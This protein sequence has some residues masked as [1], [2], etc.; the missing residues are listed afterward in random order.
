MSEG[1]KGTALAAQT[2]NWGGHDFEGFGDDPALTIE[3]V[4]DRFVFTEG[5]DG[6]AVRAATGSKLFTVKINLLQT[7]SSNAFATAIHLADLLDPNGI[8]GVLPFIWKDSLGADLFF[9]P[10]MSIIKPT[11]VQ[12]GNTVKS[13]EWEFRAAEGV[14]TAAGAGLLGLIPSP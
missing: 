2:I 3:P 4:G 12:R 6:S 13:Q 11:T 5:A 7:S 9:S 1:L 10:A 8:A 14:L